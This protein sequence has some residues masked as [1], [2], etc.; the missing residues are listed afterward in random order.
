MQNNETKPVITISALVNANVEHVWKCWTLP[1]HILK[2]N[3]AI[4]EWQTTFAENDLREG[5]SF[6]SRMEA[7]D[8]SM[9]FDFGGVYDVVDNHKKISY[10]MEDGRRVETTF[11]NSAEGT[12]I[13]TNFEAESM[14][15]LELQEQGWNSILQN[16]KKY[17]ESGKSEPLVF[18][19]EMAAP[20]SV[21][22]DVMIGEDSYR[23]WTKVFNE[24]SHFIGNW[25]KGCE[26]L[27][28]GVDA[29]GEQGGMV[30]F[31]KEN[32]PSKFI[33]IEHRGMLK[34][35]DKILE[36]PEVEPWKGGLENYHFIPTTEGCKLR[37]EM[38]ANDDFKSYFEETWP[39]ALDVLKQ[40]TEEK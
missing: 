38:D 29:N 37:I 25:Q 26:I 15:S 4:S 36:G 28:V 11:E 12:R 7:K 14:N 17:A 1:F 35:D 6:V 3:F 24:T 16:F 23:Q 39:K 31:I 27:F 5:G 32:M 20:P 40:L 34:G 2:W 33:S 9:G 8:G 13:V 22:Y 18:E 10:T 21:V 19:K 30:S